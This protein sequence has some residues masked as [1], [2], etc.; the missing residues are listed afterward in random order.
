VLAATATVLGVGLAEI[1]IAGVV[2]SLGLEML[3]AA[4]TV[5]VAATAER[6]DFGFSD[7]VETEAADTTAGLIFLGTLGGWTKLPSGL[8]FFGLPSGF[9]PSLRILGFFKT[10]PFG[11][12]VTVGLGFGVRVVEG[13]GGGGCDTTLLLLQF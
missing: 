12:V 10:S 4:V 13:G 1:V 9:E 7:G 8:S 6:E 11:R 2:T 3:L 5:T